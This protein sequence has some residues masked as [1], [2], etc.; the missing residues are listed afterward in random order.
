MES[1]GERLRYHGFD[2]LRAAMMLLG[3]VFHGAIPYMRTPDIAWPF[4]D[5]R[6]HP[7]FDVIVVFIHLFRM[8][9][10][11][12]M[13]GFF[14]AMLYL[15]RGEHDFVVNRAKR[16]LAPLVL[17]WPI[18]FFA[19]T[20]GFWF[21]RG[22]LN[23]QTTSSAAAYSARFLRNNNAWL[24][25]WFLYDLLFFYAA[26]LIA[27]R[28]PMLERLSAPLTAAAGKLM[29]S[30]FRSL[31]LGLLVIPTLY[32]MRTGILDSDLSW[33]P[34]APY[35]V[36][37]TL[38]WLLYRVRDVLPSLE[39]GAWMNT[40]FGLALL[41]VVLRML[42]RLRSGLFVSPFSMRLALAA[43]VGLAMALL[44]FGL[45]GL[46]LRYLNSYSRVLRYFTSASYWIYLLHLPLTI[47]ISAWL[48]PMA[49]PAVVK[50]VIVETVTLVAAVASYHWSVRSTFIGTL[51]NGVRPRATATPQP[52]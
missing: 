29:R 8:P 43:A 42:V 5:P 48:L 27:V 33:I 1:Q 24:H 11:F 46:F 15:E 2:S 30:R 31:W 9:V 40:A 44:V 38:G 39:Q 49:W 14:A 12:L 20:A 17:F 37:F 45:T 50:F 35:F 26:A 13:A 34:L 10:F 32:G 36:F 25:L 28:L 19:S 51:L 22:Q 52:G 6:T 18:L 7:L 47:W 3:I 21:G 23:L 41:P 4:K 16:I